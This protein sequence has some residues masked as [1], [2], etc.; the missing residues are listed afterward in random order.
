MGCNDA[1]PD[2]AGLRVPGTADGAE[3]RIE[4]VGIPSAS[5]P[6]RALKSSL[7]KLSLRSGELSP[8]FVLRVYLVSKDGL[9]MLHCLQFPGAPQT[10]KGALQVR[11]VRPWDAA[12]PLFFS[13]NAVAS[14]AKA[15]RA[16]EIASIVIFSSAEFDSISPVGDEGLKTSIRQEVFL[17]TADRTSNGGKREVEVPFY[18]SVYR[19]TRA[20]E[21]DHEDTDRSAVQKRL[22]RNLTW[23]LDKLLDAR[24]L[25]DQCVRVV[26]TAQQL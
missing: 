20:D 19:L 11:L 13:V 26:C 5:D 2:R 10:V 25:G 18:H 16:A 7:F 3:M 9:Q 14:N 6:A 23:E 8:R 24:D 12:D 1:S 22:L 17:A 21:G 4:H 15:T